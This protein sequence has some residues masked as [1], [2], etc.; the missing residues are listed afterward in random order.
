M[1]FAHYLHCYNSQN[2]LIYF[3]SLAA[4]G[5]DDDFLLRYTLVENFTDYDILILKDRHQFNWYLPIIPEIEKF[6]ADLIVE[7][8]Y[9]NVFALADSSGTMPLLNCLPS[10]PFFRRA[11]VVNGQVDISEE[12][13]YKYRDHMVG[14][15]D[16]SRVIGEFDKKYLQ[17]LNL[18]DYSNKFEILFYYN[19]FRSDRIYA[20]IIANFSKPNF[21]VRLDFK[22]C[23]EIPCHGAYIKDLFKSKKFIEEIKFYFS[24]YEY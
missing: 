6:I 16:L 2:L 11:V 22:R 19:Y 14:S 7:K 9:K 20:D 8:S 15:F 13:V 23:G 24:Q 12:V 3:N 5:Y 21:S 1:G 4:Y 10:N 17:P 18:I